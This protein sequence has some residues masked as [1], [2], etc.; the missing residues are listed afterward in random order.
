MSDDIHDYIELR[1]CISEAVR[2]QN[3]EWIGVNG[4]SPICDAYDQRF[5]QLLSLFAGDVKLAA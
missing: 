3:P 5:A 4:E 1:K 2:N